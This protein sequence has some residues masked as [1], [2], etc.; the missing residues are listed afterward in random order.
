MDELD[1]QKA[2]DPGFVSEPRQRDLRWWIIVRRVP[3]VDA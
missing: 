3:Q 1:R 2:Q